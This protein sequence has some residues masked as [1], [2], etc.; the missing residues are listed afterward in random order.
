M[1]RAAALL[2]L[3]TLPAY[4]QDADP[5]GQLVEGFMG[6]MVGAGD[7]DATTGALAAV[8]WTVS[9]DGEDGLIYF[10]P[11]VGEE[12][13]A[14]M[15]DDGSFCHVESLSQSTEIAA[16]ALQ[17]AIEAN[18][19]TWEPSKDDMGCTRFDLN[20]GVQATL[21]SGGQDPIC[22]AEDNS[23]VRFAFSE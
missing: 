12:T 10:Y 7:L 14:F 16:Q 22:G 15:A 21:T 8:G 20:S 11:A 19:N 1:I 5:A 2:A 18:G 3:L 9:T 23:A 17:A 13:M 4:A 6:C